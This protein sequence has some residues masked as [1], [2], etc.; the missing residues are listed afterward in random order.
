MRKKID[1]QEGCW[2]DLIRVALLDLR[3]FRIFP[4][5]KVVNWKEVL[6]LCWPNSHCSLPHSLHPLSFLATSGLSRQQTTLFIWK[7]A[8]SEFR[9]C[10]VFLCQGC[11]IPASAPERGSAVSHQSRAARCPGPTGAEDRGGQLTGTLEGS[12]DVQ[13]GDQNKSHGCCLLKAWGKC[14]QVK[15]VTEIEKQWALSCASFLPLYQLAINSRNI[16]FCKIAKCLQFLGNGQ[17]S[18]VDVLLA[19]AVRRGDYGEA[20]GDCCTLTFACTEL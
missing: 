11:C 5:V 16:N 18:G 19:T 1:L 10:G 15:T 4:L 12:R 20:E 2:I 17:L 7:A 3:G 6:L 13:S 14:T 8:L 9:C